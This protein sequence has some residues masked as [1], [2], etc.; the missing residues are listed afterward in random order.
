MRGHIAAHLNQDGRVLRAGLYRARVE[1][2]GEGPGEGLEEADDAWDA[3][4]DT[5]VLR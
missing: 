2:Q 1:P 3:D 5:I 4:A